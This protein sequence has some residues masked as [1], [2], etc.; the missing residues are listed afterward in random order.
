MK[1]PPDPYP[2]D[3]VAT[4]KLWQQLTNNSILAI[5]ASNLPFFLCWYVSCDD[6]Y[7]ISPSSDKNF[8]FGTQHKR[9]NMPRRLLQVMGMMGDMLSYMHELFYMVTLLLSCLY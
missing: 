9:N 3:T 6:L 8:L 2:T 4:S 7:K 1:A 5:E